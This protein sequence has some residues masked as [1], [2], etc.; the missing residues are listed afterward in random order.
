MS[1]KNKTK[2]IDWNEGIIDLM[3]EEDQIR[4]FKKFEEVIL[5]MKKTAIGRRRLAKA[6][7]RKPSDFR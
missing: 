5:E 2:D 1:K 7:E 3:P 4:I 6:F